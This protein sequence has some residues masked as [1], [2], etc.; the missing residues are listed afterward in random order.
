MKTRDAEAGT[1]NRFETAL[2]FIVQVAA[3]GLMGAGLWEISHAVAMVV[4]GGLIVVLSLIGRL[5]R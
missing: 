3:L 5:R 2:R 4:M 1:R